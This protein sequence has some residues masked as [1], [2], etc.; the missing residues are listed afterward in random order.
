MSACA[1]QVC[2]RGG[3]G[4]LSG[5]R[6]TVG[7]RKK[8]SRRKIENEINNV[9]SSDPICIPTPGFYPV[10]PT[11]PT[12][13]P[14]F[15]SRSLPCRVRLLSKQ[16]AKSRLFL[17][18]SSPYGRMEGFGKPQPAKPLH[19]ILLHLPSLTS[20]LSLSFAVLTLCLGSVWST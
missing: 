1:E 20:P 4:G 16:K 10:P 12:R 15:S 9:T 6:W 13:L 7:V 11:R 17:C 8:R 5:R 3:G 18:L 19:C 2:V 14:L